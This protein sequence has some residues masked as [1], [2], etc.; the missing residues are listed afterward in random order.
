MI[1]R[2]VPVQREYVKKMHQT[3]DKRHVYELSAYDFTS[4]YS[5]NHKYFFELSKIINPSKLGMIL[6]YEGKK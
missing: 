2:F 4:L 5:I 1:C 6:F 3:D